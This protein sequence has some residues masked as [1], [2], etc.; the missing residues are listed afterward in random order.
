VLKRL[1]VDN[2]D[3]VDKINDL[4]FTFAT[5]TKETEMKLKTK[6]K[7]RVE[8]IL[9]QGMLREIIGIQNRKEARRYLENKLANQKN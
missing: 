9:K 8:Q 7:E 5:A 6:D 4:Q 3:N 1:G 2:F